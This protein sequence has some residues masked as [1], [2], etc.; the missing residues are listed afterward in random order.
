MYF[1]IGIPAHWVLGVPAK[2]GLESSIKKFKPHFSHII[3]A[4][5]VCVHVRAASS[6]ELWLEAVAAAADAAVVAVESHCSVN[7]SAVRFGA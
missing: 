6:L 1:A 2:T 4:F 7:L 5:P 3:P